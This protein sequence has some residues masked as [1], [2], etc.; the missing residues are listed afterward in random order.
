[1]LLP[2]VSPPV[3]RPVIFET[4][5]LIVE[6]PSVQD[7]RKMK[8]LFKLVGGSKFNPNEPQRLLPPLPCFAHMMWACG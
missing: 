5:L 7:P 4:A 8:K 6:E 3:D 2:K 1:M